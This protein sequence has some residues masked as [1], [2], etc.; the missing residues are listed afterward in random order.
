MTK[1][2]YKQL[3][4]ILSLLLA[5][6]FLGPLGALAQDNNEVFPTPKVVVTVER[7]TIGQGF[8]I[9]PTL[10][11]LAENDTAYD[12]LAKVVEPENIIGDSRVVTGIKGTDQGLE[13]ITIPDYIVDDLAGPDTDL[14]KAYG[15]D[16]EEMALG[17]NSYSDQGHWIC[18]VNNKPLTR[19]WGLEPIEQGDIL[20]FAFSYWGAGADV[21]GFSDGEPEPAIEI[22]NKDDLIKTM[23][24]INEGLI[25]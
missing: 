12:L 25:Y 11:D 4:I 3:S 20:R 19:G 16:L 15:N 22:G 23:A 10:V 14:A 8:F 9:E 2:M 17:T 13:T 7:S 21:T 5:I 6:S 1:K 24:L 18:L